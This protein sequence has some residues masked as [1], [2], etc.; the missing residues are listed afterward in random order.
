MGVDPLIGS[1]AVVAVDR[2]EEPP[3]AATKSTP[4]ATETFETDI[5]AASS[6]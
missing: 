1:G 2:G 6:E 5:M 3:H 4:T